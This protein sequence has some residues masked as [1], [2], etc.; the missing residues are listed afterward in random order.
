MRVSLD[1]GTMRITRRIKVEV[2]TFNG[3]YDPKIFSDC[4]AYMDY[5]FEWY[6]MSKERKMRFARRRLTEPTR[7]YCINR[8]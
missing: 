3:T 2:L 8:V 1:P 7:I 4:W 6:D 5:Y